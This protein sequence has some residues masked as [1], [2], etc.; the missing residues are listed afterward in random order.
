MPT[1]KPLQPLQEEFLGKRGLNTRETARYTGMSPQFF[2][3]DRTTRRVYPGR[4]PGPQ[5]VRFG[6]AIRYLKDDLDAWLEKYRVP[7]WAD[8]GGFKNR[9]PVSAP[10]QM[11]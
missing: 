9:R 6:R 7:Y 11:A 5:F 1:T 8:Q 10:R 4:V 3:Q 2:I